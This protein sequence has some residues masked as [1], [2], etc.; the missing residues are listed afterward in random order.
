VFLAPRWKWLGVL[1]LLAPRRADRMLAQR[2]GRAP[3]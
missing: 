2:L 3:K 1:S